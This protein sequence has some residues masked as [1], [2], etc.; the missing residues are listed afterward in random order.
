MFEVGKKVYYA[1]QL[2]TSRGF[3]SYGKYVAT[4]VKVNAKS[5]V[6]ES[7][8]GVVFRVSKENMWTWIENFDRLERAAAAIAKE[9]KTKIAL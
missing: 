3:I 1:K 4:V 9:L 2:W 8:P 7:R 5:V 6:L